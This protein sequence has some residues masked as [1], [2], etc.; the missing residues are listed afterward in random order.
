MDWYSAVG[1]LVRVSSLVAQGF[2]GAFTAAGTGHEG[3][4]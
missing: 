2:H 1:M 4:S 3:S